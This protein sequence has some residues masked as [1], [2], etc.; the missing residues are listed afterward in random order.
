MNITPASI[1]EQKFAKAMRGYSP[2]EVEEFLNKLADE[3]DALLKEQGETKTELEKAQAIIEAYKRIETNLRDTLSKANESSTQ[4]INNAKKQADSL[5]KDAEEKSAQM[6]QKAEEEAESIRSAVL[7]LK[8]ERN[9]I[10]ARL[11][12]IINSQ[13]AL[14]EMK[15]ESIDNERPLPKRINDNDMF[16]FNI[17]AIIEK[18]L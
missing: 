2:E 18:L 6:V 3:L 15:I 12:A 4:S 1:K 9:M 10:V 11:K 16:E 14:L 5:L 8:E 17:D 13:A 7:S